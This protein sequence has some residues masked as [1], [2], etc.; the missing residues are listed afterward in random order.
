MPAVK[1]LLGFLN[2]VPSPIHEIVVHSPD[3]RPGHVLPPASPAGAENPRGQVGPESFLDARVSWTHREI[4]D[5][6]VPYPGE[7]TREIDTGGKEEASK[8]DSD[9]SST[10]SSDEDDTKKAEGGDARKEEGGGTDASVLL[11]L[12][13]VTDELAREKRKKLAQEKRRRKRLKQKKRRERRQQLQQRQ[14]FAVVIGGNVH[15]FGC[16]FIIWTLDSIRDM[17]AAARTDGTAMYG[18][19]SLSPKLLLHPKLAAGAVMGSIIVNCSLRALLRIIFVLQSICFCCFRCCCG[20]VF[21]N[22]K[23]MYNAVEANGVD[24]MV[25][26]APNA[27]APILALKTPRLPRR[28]A[29]M[30]RAP[31]LAQSNDRGG[32]IDEYDILKTTFGRL[33]VAKLLLAGL[34]LIVWFYLTFNMRDF[35]SYLYNEWMPDVRNYW[36]NEAKEFAKSGNKRF[37]TYGVPVV[38]F[39]TGATWWL[40]VLICL[41]LGPF[42]FFPVLT[43]WIDFGYVRYDTGKIMYAKAGRFI[44]WLLVWVPGLPVYMYLTALIHVH[45]GRWFA[46]AAIVGSGMWFWSTAP[47]SIYSAMV[48][49][50]CCLCLGMLAEKWSYGYSEDE[51]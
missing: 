17:S 9:S 19:V 12:K 44:P 1:V 10:E 38:T 22:N 15:L 41:C 4:R 50:S 27:P 47:Y 21:I 51:D 37:E 34:L 39:L 24:A 6:T 13:K 29:L 7:A 18:P 14:Q 48:A 26:P 49:F 40:C 11:M 20:C 46:L 23:K 3:R 35:H 42:F 28:G 31:W 5:M 16:P 33:W 25:W 32:S 43:H 36:E 2:T 8:N 30:T 45:M